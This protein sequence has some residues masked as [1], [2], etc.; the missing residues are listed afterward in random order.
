MYNFLY[1][2]YNKSS[3]AQNKTNNP[4]RTNYKLEE[5]T[6]QNYVLEVIVFIIK[7][8]SIILAMIIYNKNITSAIG[9]LGK[10]S[11]QGYSKEG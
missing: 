4:V 7:I 6:I 1:R 10:A 2:P 5:V 11:S 9:I 8:M 3:Y